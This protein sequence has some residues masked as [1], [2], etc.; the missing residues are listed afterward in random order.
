[1]IKSGVS[2]IYQSIVPDS[3]ATGIEMANNIIFNVIIVVLLLV[4]LIVLFVLYTYSARVLSIMITKTYKQ[5]DFFYR[6]IAILIPVAI[7]ITMILF[8][9]WDH[10]SDRRAIAKF[11]KENTE[12]IN[13]ED[14]LRVF[15]RNS[16]IENNLALIY[17]SRYQTTKTSEFDRLISSMTNSFEKRNKLEM[18]NTN[19]SYIIG[20]LVP[21]L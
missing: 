10:M 2:T 1:M 14:Y 20:N 16:H 11:K 19:F 8:T 5:V 17:E 18:N 15:D 21:R 4:L 6:T 9:E 13:K 3:I 7:S 12:L